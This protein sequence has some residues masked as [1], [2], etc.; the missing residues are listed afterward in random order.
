VPPLVPL[1]GV[2]SQTVSVRSVTKARANKADRLIAV[3]VRSVT[4]RGNLE[5][6]GVAQAKPHGHHTT[7]PIW[8]S[9]SAIG[10]KFCAFVSMFHGSASIR[11]GTIRHKF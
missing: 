8:S 1:S 7:S 2:C 5:G 6:A 10:G 3:S 11:Y 9:Q 4:N